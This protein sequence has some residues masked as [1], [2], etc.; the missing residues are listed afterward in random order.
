MGVT[1]ALWALCCLHA[2]LLVVLDQFFWPN[3]ACLVWFGLNWEYLVEFVG[4]LVKFPSIHISFLSPLLYFKFRWA[5]LKLWAWTTQ[6]GY[7]LIEC[8][9]ELKQDSSKIEGCYTIEVGFQ[10]LMTPWCQHDIIGFWK[11]IF[12]VFWKVWHQTDITFK[13]CWCQSDVTFG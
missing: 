3:S 5:I 11:V 1:Y 8:Y 12:N 6:I 9:W 2:P 7:W 4:C 10:L 13:N